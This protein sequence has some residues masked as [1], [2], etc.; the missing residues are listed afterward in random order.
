MT[1]ALMRGPI[2]T[3]K[4]AS[5]VSIVPFELAGT[6]QRARE[7]LAGWGDDGVDAA[8]RSLY[9]DF[10]FL[11]GYAGLGA[12]LAAASAE[13][14]GDAGRAWLTPIGWGAAAGAVLA[15]VLDA[16]ENL[17]LLRTIR[18]WRDPGADLG[19][20][21]RLARQAARTKFGLVYL[22]AGWLLLIVTPVLLLDRLE[23][24]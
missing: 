23:A 14:V 17:A 2:R 5:G 20:E 19:Q 11:L 7:I 18:A 9:L 16:V 1:A 22:V 24:L 12:L 3:M 10:P 15:G 13:P 4:S 8:R 6:D 21:A